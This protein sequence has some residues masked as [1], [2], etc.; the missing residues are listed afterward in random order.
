MLDAATY[1]THVESFGRALADAAEGHLAE[2][3]PSCPD[4][5]VETL[6][7]HAATF[8]QWVA[9]ILDEGGL[10]VA[11]NEV[12]EGEP[13]ELHRKEHASLVEALST[14]DFD[15]D[16]WS[17]GTDQHARFWFRR[18]AHELAIHCWDVQN[19]VGTPSPIDPALA[20]DGV[21][22]FAREFS[23]VHP[24]FG[25]GAA[26][27]LGVEGETI[28]FH[29]TDTDGEL[30]ITCRGDHWEVTNEHA[31]GSVAARGPAEDL[32]L[33]AWGRVPVSNLEVFGDASILDRWAARVSI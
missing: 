1:R 11:P 29:P 24:I 5:T 20:F 32:Y 16:C 26:A 25:P 30:L 3:V 17:W 7:K 23:P 28:H 31:K 4:F 2:G 15:H 13:I 9:A 18:A 21:D 8:C 22:E 6:V 10:A 27:K 33:F 14:V 12:G 19:A